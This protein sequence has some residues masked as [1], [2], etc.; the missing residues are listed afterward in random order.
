MKPKV[1]LETSVI[2]YA[3]ARLSN[4][5]IIAG[6]QKLTQEWWERRKPTF[7]VYISQ[8]V[9]K[10]TSVG[11][12]DAA[13]QRMLALRHIP[14]LHITDEVTRLSQ[15]FLSQN[16][17][18]KKAAGDAVHIAIATIH[19]IDY[20]L[21][22]N[23]KHIANAELRKKLSGICEQEGYTLPVICTPEELMGE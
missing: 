1:Y 10:E 8:L 18:P 7:E 5:L 15:T 4:D 22:W 13:E 16:A 19:R 14:L 9:I 23:C 6:H 11:D 2:S 21:T 3:T 17:L 20:L 12:P